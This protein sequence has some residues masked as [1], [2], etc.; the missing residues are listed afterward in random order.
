MYKKKYWI[1][2][3]VLSYHHVFF[4]YGISIALIYYI[5]RLKV[6]LYTLNTVK[7]IGGQEYDEICNFKWKL[8]VQTT[9]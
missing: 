4:K 8:Q 5:F 7:V 3:S 2:K 6:Y 9:S 1:S